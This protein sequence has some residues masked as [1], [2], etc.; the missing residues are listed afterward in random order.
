MVSLP[1]RPA[2]NAMPR[3][4]ALSLQL[5]PAAGAIVGNNL[6]EHGLERGFVELFT[7]PDAHCPGGFVVVA[8]GDNTFGIGD[9]GA[10]VE[11]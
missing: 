8:G 6:L 5:A 7:L 4:L 3:L 9:N 11:K 10:I 2:I 1:M